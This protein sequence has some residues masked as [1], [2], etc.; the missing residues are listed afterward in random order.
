M[1]EMMVIERAL[2]ADIIGEI[3]SLQLHRYEDYA[4][5]VGIVV[6]LEN[7]MKNSDNF[8]PEEVKLNG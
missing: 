8:K 2:M 1:N 4:R 7:A 5:I 6:L 3:K